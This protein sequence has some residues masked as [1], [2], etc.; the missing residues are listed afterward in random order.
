MNEK[1][2]G[3]PGTVQAPGRTASRSMA[4]HDGS[5]PESR[6]EPIPEPFSA[7]ELRRISAEVAAWDRPPAEATRLSLMEVDPWNL[8]AYWHIDPADMVAG[9]AKLGD[10]GEHAGLV[11]RFCDISPRLDD[12][13]PHNGFDIEVGEGSN[14]QYVNLWRDAKRYSAEIG[15]RAH[16]GA[17]MPLAR[18]NEVA[19]PRAGPSPALDFLRVETCAPTIPEPGAVGGSTLQSDILLRD[20]F[21]QRLS[22]VD[23]YPLA[24]AESLDHPVVEPQFPNLDVF[25]QETVGADVFAHEEFEPRPVGSPVTADSAETA[26]D[27]TGFPVIE[28]DELDDYHE[29]ARMVKDAVLA[30]VRPPHLPRVA[31][32]MVAPTDIEL[33]PQ[34]LPIGPAAT[35][36]E[37]PVIGPGAAPVRAPGERER[38]PIPVALEAVLGRSV[39]SSGA[40]DAAVDV[41]ASL[42]IEGRSAADTLVTLFGEPVPLQPD[43][44]FALSLSLEREPDLIALLHRVRG[45]HRER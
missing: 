20:L 15:L 13:L 32:E 16:D 33:F 38:A 5:R 3:S 24:F 37:A 31:V 26:L 41:S 10:D 34:P 40:A 14:N 45:R 30:D 18:S 35:A 11:L 4:V 8:H 27:S 2:T 21:P 43:G 1:T 23:D 39:F 29:L 17:F 7:A 42:V 19:T 12:A 25:M 9:R 44:R 22:T 28:A 36:G 6:V